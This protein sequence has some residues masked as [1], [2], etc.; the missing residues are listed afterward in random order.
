MAFPGEKLT[1]KLW[2]TLAE[3]GIGGLFAPWQEKR[4]G[5]ARNEVKYE[6]IR[7]IAE[8]E[9]QAE[10]IKSGQLSYKI[11]PE[12]ALLE[13]TSAKHEGLE[14]VEPT[15]DPI[16]LVKAVSDRS[17][18]DSLRKEINVAKS[19]LVA[20]D[21]LS[22]GSKEK[23]EAD[24]D[25]ADIDEDWLYAWRDCAEKVSKEELQQLWGRVLAGEFKKPGSYSLRTLEFLKGMSVEEAKL[26]EKLG[27]FCIED[28]VFIREMVSLGNG[29]ALSQREAL[30]L[31]ELGVL[32][33]V[34]SS[35]LQQSYG[36]QSDHT[37]IKAF[38]IG[39]KAI[40]AKHKD[41]K[42]VLKVSVYLVTK[43]GVEILKVANVNVDDGYLR[44]IC[45]SL[46]N[47]GY[48]VYKASY[49]NIDSKIFQTYDEQ[50]FEL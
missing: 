36:T 43:V 19:I 22:E 11:Q 23:P 13:S 9:R 24:I 14:K 32:S 35:E 8:A 47:D 50:K 2:E 4:I 41:S 48:E 42:R 38:L 27:K 31:Q 18:A 3:K 15:F 10:L 17:A 21:V 25:E 7:L 49:R 45:R 44:A 1:I 6:E 20:E 37:Y 30:Y 39:N 5:R 16:E 34:Q 12:P 40:V 46:I 28:V 33:A 26:I 29:V